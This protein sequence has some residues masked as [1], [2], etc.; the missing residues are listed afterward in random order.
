MMTSKAEKVI[1]CTNVV[2]VIWSGV[3]AAM[4]GQSAWLIV[5]ALNVLGLILFALELRARVRTAA[6]K[7]DCMNL[8]DELEDQIHRLRAKRDGLPAVPDRWGALQ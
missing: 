8:R 7:N 2:A 6:L 4:T 3:L 1:A 5:T